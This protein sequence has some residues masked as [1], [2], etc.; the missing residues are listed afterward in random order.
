MANVNPQSI[1]EFNDRVIYRYPGGRFEQSSGS[2]AASLSSGLKTC[3]NT[4]TT[5]NYVVPAS[6]QPARFFKID[7]F[8]NCFLSVANTLN[9]GYV[10][11][12]D[13]DFSKIY[14]P[15]NYD[16]KSLQT[17]FYEKNTTNFY[18]S[19]QFRSLS[20]ADISVEPVAG[21]LMAANNG[22]FAYNTGVSFIVAIMQP[23]ITYFK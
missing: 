22:Y 4:D 11:L 21:V 17:E 13:L 12:V 1:E 7:L 5:R 8:F 15:L 16:G 23:V 20:I 3:V 2:F 9:G 6:N 10:Q 18:T 14:A 19:R